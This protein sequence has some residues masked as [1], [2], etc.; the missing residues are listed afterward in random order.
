M[1]YSP[2]LFP[3]E[4]H[5][6]ERQKLAYHRCVSLRF[7]TE[8]Q[9]TSQSPASQPA[10]TR[11]AP[12]PTEYNNNKNRRHT[13]YNCLGIKPNRT[14]NQTQNCTIPSQSNYILLLLLLQ[15]DFAPDCREMNNNQINV[16][17]VRAR[18]GEFNQRERKFNVLMAHWNAWSHCEG[19]F[20]TI[21]L[22]YDCDVP[23]QQS[24]PAKWYKL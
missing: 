3:N 5:L 22:T 23:I 18:A 9:R 21:W 7:T 15:D 14:Q 6:T 17:C 1:S 16:V 20:M 4:P 10:S 8:E 12:H 13:K 2:T 19:N 24:Q 11:T